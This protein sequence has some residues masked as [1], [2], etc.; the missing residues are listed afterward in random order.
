MGLW[1]GGLGNW[2]RGGRRGEVA[3]AMIGICIGESGLGCRQFFFFVGDSGVG[4]LARGVC[5]CI[6]WSAPWIDASTS[7]DWI[8]SVAKTCGIISAS[9]LMCLL[10]RWCSITRERREM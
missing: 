4:E 2:A 5:I 10:N 3:L 8:S 6:L 9:M 1:A 7:A